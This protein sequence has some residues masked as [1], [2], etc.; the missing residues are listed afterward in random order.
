MHPPAP[1]IL[2]S[3]VLIAIIAEASSEP[4][5]TI[6][7]ATI[8]TAKITTATITTATIAGNKDSNTLHCYEYRGRLEEDRPVHDGKQC[9]SRA[10]CGQIYDKKRDTWEMFCDERELCK[11]NGISN[12]GCI[13]VS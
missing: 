12:G 5:T 1:R 9:N 2:K 10:P 4:T 11:R 3:Y 6:T 8:T 13:N 7:T